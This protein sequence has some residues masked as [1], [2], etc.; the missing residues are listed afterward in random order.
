MT[1][2]SVLNI[3]QSAA[4]SNTTAFAVTIP[5]STAGSTFVI[6]Y[7]AGNNDNALSSVT[8]GSGTWSQKQSENSANTVSCWGLLTGVSAGTT[9][10]TFNLAATDSPTVVIFEVANLSGAID[11]NS[12]IKD[13]S[14]TTTVTGNTITTTNPVDLVIG[15]I[16]GWPPAGGAVTVTPTSSGYTNQTAIVNSSANGG[17]NYIQTGYQVTSAT[18]TFGYNATTNQNTTSATYVIALSGSVDNF[19]DGFSDVL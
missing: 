13:T 11:Q 1:T 3:T 5:A 9:T 4:G 6:F 17:H 16:L 7:E 15:A 8:G 2:P 14:T 10:L 18:G 19:G 12:T